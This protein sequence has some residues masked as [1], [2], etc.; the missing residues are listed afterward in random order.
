[1]VGALSWGIVWIIISGVVWLPN[2]TNTLAHLVGV[3]RGA[4]AMIYASIITLFY[5]VFRLY[6][7]S[8]YLSHEI[9]HLVRALSMKDRE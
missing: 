1:M 8:E 3:G 9:T 7:K 5:A 2:L 6:V 4:D